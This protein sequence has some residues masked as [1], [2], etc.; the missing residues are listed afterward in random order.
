M[1]QG[2]VTFSHLLSEKGKVRTDFSLFAKSLLDLGHYRDS[3]VKKSLEG[4]EQPRVQ[5]PALS[6]A[7]ED[8]YHLGSTFLLVK[9]AL[10]SLTLL[11]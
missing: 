2:M 4:E 7:I 8:L 11:H 10:Q 3:N 5:S 1:R 9:W 6:Q